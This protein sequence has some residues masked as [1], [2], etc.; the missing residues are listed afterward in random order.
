MSNISQW[1][2]T[3]GDNS[4]APP[5]GW[6]EGQARST[7]NDCAREMM[8]AVA[9]DFEDRKGSLASA[10][11][12]N[13]YTVT[14][15]NDNQSLADIGLLTFRVDRA[16]TGAVTLNVDGLGAKAWQKR[17]GIAYASGDLIA[18]QLVT[19]AYNSENDAFETIGGQSGEFDS[20]TA[21]LFMQTAAP[22]GW[23]KDT[24]ANLND[25]S[26]R[27]VTGTPSSR[28]NQSA[29]STVFGKTAVDGTSLNISQLPSHN[30]AS[31]SISTTGTGD[32]YARCTSSA[33]NNAGTWF[34]QSG[35]QAGGGVSAVTNFDTG[36]TTFNINVH[37]LQTIGTS[38]S[39]GSGSTHA[40]D[41]DIRVNYHDVIKATKD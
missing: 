27:L 19:V 37:N 31:G 11:S 7:V 18:D 10:G 8:A 29:F 24:T 39:T 23:T 25:T 33:T 15:N 28:T 40:H 36:G 1:Q 20:G 30:H 41:M 12:S 14:T 22:T 6:P 13:A 16:N 21:M 38:G 9:R 2:V 34:D 5:N 3:A 35:A 4:S 32:R 17:S 26:L